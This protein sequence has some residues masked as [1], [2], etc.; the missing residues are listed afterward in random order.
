MMQARK[1]ANLT[2]SIIARSCNKIMIGKTYWKNVV[3]PGALYA[4]SILTW[5][6][7]EKDELL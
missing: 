3:L 4:L 5:T 1:M 6:R 7:N 2:Y